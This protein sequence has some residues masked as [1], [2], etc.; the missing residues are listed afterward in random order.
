MSAYTNQT[1][2]TPATSYFTTRQEV[3]QLINSISSLSSV[4]SFTPNPQFST[5]SMPPS[6]SIAAPG[7]VQATHLNV[8]T[9]GMMI[10]SRQTAGG[11]SYVGVQNSGGTAN[12]YVECAG[13]M[14]AVLPGTAGGGQQGLAYAFNGIQGLTS[15]NTAVPL[16][17]YNGS[18]FAMSNIASLNTTATGSLNA[19]TANISTLN[20][21]SFS[22]SAIAI[23]NLTTSNINTST[24][25]ATSRISTSALFAGALTAGSFSASVLAGTQVQ[26]N[27]A[28]T[29]N[30]F[31]VQSQAYGAAPTTA[32][33]LVGS[34]ASGRLEAG[35]LQLTTNP[36]NNGQTSN[37]LFATTS[38]LGFLRGGAGTSIP[39]LTYNGTTGMAL[40]NISS[41]N[42]SA[43]ESVP[44]W[45]DY[46]VVNTGTQAVAVAQAFQNVLT[47]TN[48]PITAAI[49]RAVLISVP[50]AFSLSSPA[51]GAFTL[52]LRAFIGG[53]TSA[54]SSV[55]NSYTFQSGSSGGTL[56]LSGV[57]ICNGTTNSL[58]IQAAIDSP[59]IGA[60]INFVQG[61]GTLYSFFFLQVV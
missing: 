43:I 20:A 4:A 61:S 45:I 44:T 47:F 11:Q 51:T 23:T 25:T 8:S 3:L 46:T 16:V 17:S 48:I 56:T 10:T 21:N 34:S 22:T 41:I 60:T 58:V 9:T 15:S 12:Q 38:N 37:A 54:G 40:Q 14:T 24:L 32:L 52:Q 39:A 2:I 42:G 49:N 35:Y 5:I 18:N 29:S 13:M 7:G 33:G 6:G 50:I 53:S 57:C 31:A 36:G 30:Y 28:S 59:S 1:N 55:N 27:G 19:T 26:V